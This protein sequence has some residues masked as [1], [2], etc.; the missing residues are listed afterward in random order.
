[1]GK[2]INAIAVMPS[3]SQDCHKV[4]MPLAVPGVADKFARSAQADMA[5]PGM[6]IVQI[7]D[8]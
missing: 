1:V 3:L 7:A 6:M 8:L 5:S 4:D 2:Y